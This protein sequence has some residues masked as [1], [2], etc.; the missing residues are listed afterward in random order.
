M[1]TKINDFSPKTHGYVASMSK[2]KDFL[3]IICVLD[4]KTT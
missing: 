1:T 2:I 4:V 3:K